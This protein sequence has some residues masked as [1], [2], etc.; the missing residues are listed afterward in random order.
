MSSGVTTNQKSTI[1]T[2]KFRCSNTNIILKKIIKPQGNALKE[3]EKYRQ[4]LHKQ[5]ENN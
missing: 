3:E 2:Q 4:E 5:S 1:Y